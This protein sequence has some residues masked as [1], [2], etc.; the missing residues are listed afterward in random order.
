MDRDPGATGPPRP[1][2]S[3]G[4][5]KANLFLR[6]F[7]GAFAATPVVYALSVL[8]LFD[9]SPLEAQLPALSASSSISLP[10]GRVHEDLRGSPV[11]MR[12]LL[13][14]AELRGFLSDETSHTSRALRGLFDTTDSVARLCTAPTGRPASR[15]YDFSCVHSLAFYSVGS[16]RTAEPFTNSRSGELNERANRHSATWS[17]AVAVT[18]T[19][20][21]S[22]RLSSQN[23]LS[24]TAGVQFCT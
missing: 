13:G 5:I 21:T 3:S 17:N 15:R 18:A 22:R 19:T 1:C 9:S 16:P 8:T 4:F 7:D 6:Q 11:P 2:A 20:S 12:V 10:R 23:M 24:P 14:T